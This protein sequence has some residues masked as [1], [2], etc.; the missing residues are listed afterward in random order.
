MKGYY[1]LSPVNI[2]LIHKGLFSIHMVSIHM[3]PSARLD[4]VHM[5]KRQGQ[6]LAYWR[7]SHK[8]DPGHVWSNAKLHTQ[9]I[10]TNYATTLWL[11]NPS[12]HSF[13]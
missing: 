13:L 3:V 2:L 11:T 8:R 1:F 5:A 10:K 7:A 6:K 9:M 4:I 12:D